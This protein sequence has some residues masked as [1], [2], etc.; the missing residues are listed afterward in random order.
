MA[1]IDVNFSHQLKTAIG[2]TIGECKGQVTGYSGSGLVAAVFPS[3][4]VCESCVFGK[5]ECSKSKAE[6]KEQI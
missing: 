5:K 3:Q 1:V 6:Q 4:S 2:D